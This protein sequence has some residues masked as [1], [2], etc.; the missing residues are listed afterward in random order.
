[1]K[2]LRAVRLQQSFVGTIGIVA[3]SGLIGVSPLEGAETSAVAGT[4]YALAKGTNEFG[5]WA[6]GSPHSSKNF[7]NV[8]DR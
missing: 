1:M 7:G 5:R 3:L 4:G 2:R 8:G 6:G